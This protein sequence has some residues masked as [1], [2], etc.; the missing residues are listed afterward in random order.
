MSLRADSVYRVDLRAEVEKDAQFPPEVLQIRLTEQALQ[1]LANAYTSSTRSAAHIRIDVDPSDPVLLIGDTS[2]SL[3]AP[4]PASGSQS[5]SDA[6]STSTAPHELYKLSKDESTLHRIGTISTKLTVK[7]T[8]DVSAV[9]QRLKQQKEEQE[10]RKQERRKALIAGASPQLSASSSSRTGTN[11]ALA[12]VRAAGAST[13]LA[14]SPLSR[15]SS[16]NK[17]SSRREPSLLQAASVSNAASREPSPGAGAGAGAG[18]SGGSPAVGAHAR[19]Q[20][21]SYHTGRTGRASTDS[22][23]T[24]AAAHPRGATAEHSPAPKA[25]SGLFDHRPNDVGEEGQYSDEERGRQPAVLSSP[26][27]GASD[28]AHGAAKKTNKL[29]TRQRLAKATKAG[30]R[31]LAVSERKATPERRPT[32][33]STQVSPPSKAG[34]SNSLTEASRSI[35]KAVAD[36]PSVAHHA[37]SPKAKA[38]QAAVSR[39]SPTARPERDDRPADGR[40]RGRTAAEKGRKLSPTPASTSKLIKDEASSGSKRRADESVS[41]KQV[42]VRRN[43]TAVTSSRASATSV[44]RKP[45]DTKAKSDVSPLDDRNVPRTSSKLVASSSSSKSAATSKHASPAPVQVVTMRKAKTSAAADAAPSKKSVAEASTASRA[46]RRSE[47]ETAKRGRPTHSETNGRSERP[48]DRE[49]ASSSTSPTKQAA[50]RKSDDHSADVGQRKRRRTNDLDPCDRLMQQHRDEKVSA[51]VGSTPLHR[52]ESLPRTREASREGSLRRVEPVSPRESTARGSIPVSASMPSFASSATRLQAVSEKAGRT[53]KEEYHDRRRDRYYDEDYEAANLEKKDSK[54][55]RSTTADDRNSSRA[56]SSTSS[57][58]AAV[59]SPS[60]QDR[61][62][63]GVGPGATH[64][65]EPWLD[66]RS[67][68][69]W[70]RLAQRFAKTQQEYLSMR[71]RL[72]AESERLDRELALASAEEQDTPRQ[73]LLFSPHKQKEVNVEMQDLAEETA[74]NTSINSQTSKVKEAGGD[75]NESPEEGEM[76]SDDEQEKQEIRRS[77]SPD[78][79][80]WRPT[81]QTQRED[82]ERPLSYTDLARKVAQLAELHASLSRMHTVLV[83][84]KSKRNAAGF[85]QSDAS[86]P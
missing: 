12:S 15:S 60:R 84:F 69:D 44:E 54:R 11:K 43:G 30:S 9:A 80:A 19:L 81:T 34:A 55:G 14:S 37:S 22:P 82:G 70:H 25:G 2:F 1:Q 47:T 4:L 21:A 20:G 26:A 39:S 66:V 31:L 18:A 36:E 32:P 10:Q 62:I 79:L 17:L 52:N 57:T 51:S 58:V 23:K 41:Q 61:P 68:S 59:K 42:Q 73:S 77:E 71:K 50:A 8:R 13:L 3:H 76:Q 40:I 35:P 27:S 46:S 78:N 33:S 28:L 83:E 67:R 85:K 56:L 48:A 5:A 64:W 75:G 6:A 29:T 7:P 45:V 63:K 65:S 53:N 86:F 24:A 74:V 72:E 16:L 49:T 38:S